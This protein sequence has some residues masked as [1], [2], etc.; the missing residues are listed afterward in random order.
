[1]LREFQDE[2]QRLRAELAVSILQVLGVVSPSLLLC[3]PPPANLTCGLCALC[4]GR[5]QREAAAEAWR[6]LAAMAASRKWSG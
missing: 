1:M 6:V 4:V 2:I 5:R 3:A